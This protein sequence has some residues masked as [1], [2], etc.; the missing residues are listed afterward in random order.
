MLEMWRFA[1]GKSVEDVE[2]DWAEWGPK[3]REL[4]EKGHGEPTDTEK[5]V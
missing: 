4:I 2:R 5:V 1:R 3:I